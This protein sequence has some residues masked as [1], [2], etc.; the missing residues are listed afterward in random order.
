MAQQAQTAGMRGQAHTL[1]RLLDEYGESHVH[2]ANK[3][4][5]F[6][7]V[8]LIVLSIM[9]LLCALPFPHALSRTVPWLGWGGVAALAAVA[10]YLTLSTSLAAGSLIV[11]GLMLAA[12]HGLAALPWPLWLTSLSVFV[13]AWIGQFVGHA[14]EGKRPSFFKDAQFLLIGPLWLLD[15]LYRRLGLHG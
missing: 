7:C 10:Y 1:A 13:L 12:T 6:I 8:P 4:L 2:P 5:H 3:R 9:G 14:I 11:L 15:H